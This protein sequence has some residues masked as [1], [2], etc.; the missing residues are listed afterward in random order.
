MAKYTYCVDVNGTPYNIK[1]SLILTNIFDL[2]GLSQPRSQVF[3][4]LKNERAA[5]IDARF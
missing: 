5:G 3:L 2:E 4:I 1:S